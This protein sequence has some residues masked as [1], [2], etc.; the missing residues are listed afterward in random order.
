MPKCPRANERA[1]IRLSAV[2]AGIGR[3]SDPPLPYAGE[4]TTLEKLVIL[5]SRNEITV[6][7]N[8]KLHHLIKKP[9]PEPGQ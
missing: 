7:S 2:Y 4:K 5:S 3:G 9:R 1:G 8:I 6:T